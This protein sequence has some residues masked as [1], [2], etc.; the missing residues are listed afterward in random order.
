MAAKKPSLFARAKAPPAFNVKRARR[1]DDGAYPGPAEQFLNAETG[2][3]YDKR[4]ATLLAPFKPLSQPQRDSLYRGNDVAARAVDLIVGEATRR[5]IDVPSDTERR[6]A[7]K[8]TELGVQAAFKK[9]LTIMRV[10]GGAVIVIGAAD[11]Q[12]L[13]RP[14]DELAVRDINYLNV[15]R[16][17]DISVRE[18]Y[19]NPLAAKYGQPLMYQIAGQEALIHESRVLRFEHAPTDSPEF[20]FPEWGPGV[21]DR[22]YTVIRDTCAAYSGVGLLL[23]EYSQAVYKL[24][25]LA[26]MLAADDEG[27]VL[28][29]IGQLDRSRSVARPIA[30]DAAHENFERVSPSGATGLADLIDRLNIRVAA[31][32]G[33]PVTLFWGVSPAGMQSTG[34]G[35]ER[36]FYDS[37]SAFQE[38][39]MRH[40][41]AR[42]LR[43]IARVT[44]DV[45]K[46]ASDTDVPFEFV[47]LYSPSEVDLAT[48]HNLQAQ[49]D[50]KYVAMGAATA[51]EIRTSRFRGGFSYD[52]IASGPAPKQ[53]EA[54]NVESDDKPSV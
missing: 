33:Y 47:S 49:A 5:W 40:P 1:L 44:G 41:L 27:V 19:T 7:R 53:P 4:S 34:K 29:R 45:R 28:T 25:G 20:D 11:G 42:V 23:T 46:N 9:A 54:Q 52:T 16:C 17:Y 24:Q 18:R 36:S 2:L 22:V 8:C 12:P 6:I 35:E 14:L 50:E 43:I 32:T 31:A 51:D 48:A 38:A 10:H 13:S 37:V 26:E 15:L 39:H 30:L 21:L 3:G